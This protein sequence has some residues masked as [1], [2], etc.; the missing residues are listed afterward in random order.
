MASRLASA[1]EALI[2]S[3]AARTRRWS[4]A[5]AVER[6]ERLEHGQERHLAGLVAGDRGLVG[7]PCLRQ[8]AVGVDGGHPLRGAELRRA[9]PRAEAD[10]RAY[11]L[12]PERGRAATRLRLR[13]RGV[14]PLA[15]EG[16]GH[17]DAGLPHGI[18]AAPVHVAGLD[19]EVGLEVAARQVDREPLALDAGGTGA[20]LG[21]GGLG[22]RL[23][24]EEVARL[25]PQ[26]EPDAGGG[27]GR[28]LAPDEARELGQPRLPLRLPLRP[29]LLE[30][31]DL[32]L[33]AEDVLLRALAHR[34]AGA[35]DA[36]GLLPDV[37]LLAEDAERLLG[38]GPGPRRRGGRRR[39]R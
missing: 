35:R 19:G 22:L 26:G 15:E 37:L 6:R 2:R 4:D 3:C 1:I 13:D 9:L 12:D 27:V 38:R 16:Q 29:Q 34:V 8:K 28:H 36:L 11:R 30:A 7:Q 32:H 23:Q 39:R 18:E 21:E 5:V 10:L 20:Q 33:G 31:G 17:P 14:A 24:R 25:R